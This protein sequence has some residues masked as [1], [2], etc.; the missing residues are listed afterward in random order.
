MSCLLAF[1]AN[2]VSHRAFEIKMSFIAEKVSFYLHRQ[3][4]TGW[5][6]LFTRI[7]HSSRVAWMKG[8]WIGRQAMHFAIF[9]PFIQRTR[10]I[11]GRLNFTNIVFP[12]TLAHV[13][14]LSPT[15]KSTRV[16]ALLHWVAVAAAKLKSPSRILKR[17][18]NYIENHSQRQW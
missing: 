12:Q 11:K 8:I 9:L 5:T 10:F 7:V 2:P 1:V 3:T 17:W 13:P 16:D 6:V 18:K 14:L 15:T 4:L